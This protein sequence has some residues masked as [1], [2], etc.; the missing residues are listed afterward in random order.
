MLINKKK[1]T[2]VVKGFKIFK[3]VLLKLY[4]KFK[5]CLKIFEKILENYMKVLWKVLFREFSLISL[6]PV[7][8]TAER[9]VR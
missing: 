9:D 5:N 6:C 4:Q 7:L 3:K 8:Y 2:R 1:K